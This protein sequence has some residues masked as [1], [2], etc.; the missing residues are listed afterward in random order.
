MK[1]LSYVL[2]PIFGVVFCLILLVFHPMQW[3]SLKGFGYNGHKKVVSLL[4]LCINKSLL[5]LG[6]RVKF[7]N[8]YDLPQGSILIFVSNHQSIFDIP[9]IEWYLRK[10]HVKFV[11]KIELAKGIPS[12]SFNLRHGGAALIDRKDGRQSIV[13]LARF[14]KNI[15]KNKWSALI[16][17]EGTRG[18]NGKVKSFAPNG[19]KTI[20]KYNPEAYIVPLTINN[21]WKIFKYGKFPFGLG[22]PLILETH[23]PIKIDSLPFEELIMKVES[24]ITNSIK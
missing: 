5:I 6:I 15:N 4:N 14:S 19:V 8:K 11:S 22:T 9:P 2:S 23:E 16:F 7:K 20:I 18:R 3:I 24:T 12:I 17:P 13:E 21:S 10:H 1:I